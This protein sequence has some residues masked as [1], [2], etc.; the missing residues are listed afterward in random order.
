MKKS[1]LHPQP[2]AA[3]PRPQSRMQSLCGSRKRKERNQA[4]QQRLEAPLRSP[5]RTSTAAQQS[6][7]DAGE[8]SS[9]RHQRHGPD[10]RTKK[11]EKTMRRGVRRKVLFIQATQHSKSRRHVPSRLRSRYHVRTASSQQAQTKAAMRAMQA[12]SPSSHTV[13]RVLMAKRP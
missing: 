5:R 4:K 8:S 9:R 12:Q 13:L 3:T 2:R 6:G 1:K 11:A 7:S 10:S